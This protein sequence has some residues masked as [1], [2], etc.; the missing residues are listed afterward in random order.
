[1]SFAKRND[2]DLFLSVHANAFNAEANGT[3]TYYYAASNQ[4][5]SESRALA[6]YIQKRLLASWKLNDRGVKHGDF[7]VIRENNMPAVLLELGFLD[8][9]SDVPKLASSTWRKEAAKATYLGILDYYHHYEGKNVSK[10]YGQVNASVSP[11]YH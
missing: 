11:K 1:M 2:A 5:T 10:Y 7:H 9:K 4:N 6:T 8:A 3:E